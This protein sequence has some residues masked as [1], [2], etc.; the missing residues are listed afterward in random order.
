MQW[1][2]AV[3]VLVAPNESSFTQGKQHLPGFFDLYWDEAKGELFLAIDEFA[4]PFLLVNS[5]ATGLGSNDIGLDRGQLGDE[6]VVHFERV[7]NR[8]FLVEPNLLY[9]ADSNNPLEK[10]AVAESFASSTHW[11]TD[12]V[13]EEDG[14]VFVN[15]KDYVMKDSH[16][17]IDRLKWRKE[18]N[19]QLEKSLG[20]YYRPRIK[21][22]PDNSEVEVSL[23]YAG[24]PT[25]SNLR[26]VV[27]DPGAI[28]LRLHY[29]FI[30]LPDQGY[31]PR[32]YHPRSGGWSTSYRDY[33]AGLGESLDKRFVMRHRLV[34]KNPKA[35]RSELVEPLVY[36]VDSGAPPQIQQALI[37][38]ASWWNQAFEA[39]GIIDGFQ[40][41]VLPAD[42]DPMDVRYNVIQWV[43]RA[44][45]GWSYGGSI[46]DPRT[47][48][49]IKGHVT[50]GSLR[51]RQD[52]LLFEGMLA[53][54]TK[55]TGETDAVE[56]ALSRIR[57]LSAHEVG[58]TL[59]LAHN[60]AASTYNRGSVMDYPAPLVTL[61]NGV[62]D[63]SKAYETGIGAWDK[64][65]ISYLYGEWDN[66]AKGLAE[67]IADGEKA[68]MLFITD[69]DSR[70]PGSMH[71]LSNL[72]DNGSDPIEEL[73][74]LYE[75]RS[76]L[77]AHFKPEKLDP[78][79]PQANLEEFLVPIYLNHRYQLEAVGKYLGG[80]YYDYALNRDPRH[81]K[82]VDEETQRKAL[83]QLVASLKPE[84]LDLPENLRHIIP[85]RAYGFGRHRELFESKAG[86]AFDALTMAET[87]IDMTFDEL[88][89]P[90]RVNRLVLQAEGQYQWGLREM[91]SGLLN[92]TILSGK[93]KGRAGVLHRMV[94]VKL[95]ER[96]N[97]MLNNADLYPEAR[98]E[99]LAYIR[100]LI[101]RLDRK[102]PN[103]L[104]EPLDQ[105]NSND[106]ETRTWKLNYNRHYIY[107]YKLL[108]TALAEDGLKPSNVPEPPP[109]SP[110]G[111]PR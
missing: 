8:V 58:H 36:Y 6:K 78:G 31:H 91:I 37:E 30:R 107:I 103:N 34:R 43:H 81:F 72:W 67:V 49:I 86:R 11:G 52:R 90:N 99:F 98:A 48:E 23:T 69:Q 76:H 53:N 12:I 97:E 42:A 88:F 4:K 41:K 84:F 16:G 63:F 24:Q 46:A 110:I 19:Y 47:G 64:L 89:Q 65:S 92:E 28:T 57:Q 100:V 108:T 80:A 40:V 18:G 94:N 1:L 50:L 93:P 10:R 32:V 60:F 70:V 21:A 105:A 59:G 15:L 66:E 17:V 55:K 9:R 73:G 26:G 85:P 35:K 38:G 13:A 83:A 82:L 74:R 51:V 56:L 3:L 7:G 95:A 45:R 54:D 5:L 20:H 29:S 102:N 25:G 96:F 87:A 27:A 33:A 71:P 79:M 22:F 14:R 68:G 39:A 111:A 62:L 61:E 101:G 104:Y 75:L 44:T 2:I 77:L 109:G 106:A